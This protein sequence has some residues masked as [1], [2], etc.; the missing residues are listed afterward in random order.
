MSENWTEEELRQRN[1]EVFGG[2]E[3][4]P[5]PVQ[6]VSITMK[7]KRNKYGVAP[8]DERTVEGIV[9]AS[10]AEAHAYQTLKALYDTGQLI[11]LKLQPRFPF[12]MCFSYVAD[13]DVTYADGSRFIIDVKGMETPE[14]KLKRKCFAH[15]YP[16]LKLE[17][18]KR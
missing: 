1:R 15:F 2:V 9:F 11:S 14:F 16:E 5:D 3:I 4:W 13:F 12:P 17:V 10:K 8:K 6:D 18:W 7:P